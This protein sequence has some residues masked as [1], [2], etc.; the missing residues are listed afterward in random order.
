MAIPKAVD[1]G[2]LLGAGHARRSTIQLERLAG[3]SVYHR[4]LPLLGDGL[5]AVAGRQ[6]FWLVHAL[7]R[8]NANIL[9][10]VSNDELASVLPG[11]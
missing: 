3:G 11:R 1:R 2:G 10:C 8:W 4:R 5:T 6:N 9:S 7:L